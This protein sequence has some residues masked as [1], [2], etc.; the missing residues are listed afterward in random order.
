MTRIRIDLEIGR[1]IVAEIQSRAETCRQ[2]AQ[3]ALDATQSAPSY[4]GQFGPMVGAIGADLFARYS[5]Q[6]QALEQ[7]AQDLQAIVEAFERADQVIQVDVDRLHGMLAKFLEQHGFVLRTWASLGMLMDR[8]FGGL[9]RWNAILG[10]GPP[11]GIPDDVWRSHTIPEKLALWRDAGGV[12]GRQPPE[13]ASL[14]SPAH[15]TQDSGSGPF[16]SMEP[17][18]ADFAFEGALLAGAAQ[19]DLVQDRPDAARHMRHYLEGSGEPLV[20][21]VNNMLHNL[22]K[23]QQVSQAA[24]DGF[25]EDI[26]LEVGRQYDGNPLQLQTTSPWHGDYYAMQ[27]DN[28]NWFFAMGGFSYAYS[29]EVNV[30]PPMVAGGNPTVEISYQMHI[31]DYYNW[32]QGKAVTIPRPTIPLSGDPLSLPIPEEYQGHI[33]EVGNSWRV[34]DTA[35]SRLHL[36]GLAQE[37]EITGQTEVSTRSYTLDAQSMQLEPAQPPLA[38]PRTGR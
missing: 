17:T 2:L 19:W 16:D 22:P 34:Q 4:D 7:D 10:A 32:D 6:T 13:T 26:E 21:D 29:A 35:L 36:G 27:A 15:P 11:P 23:F 18:L 31:W 30:T 20:V 8:G 38:G 3:A 25:I 33:E 1:Q 5:R 12:D 28:P 24:L 14:P 37:Y 9:G